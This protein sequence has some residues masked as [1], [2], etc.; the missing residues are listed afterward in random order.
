MNFWFQESETNMNAF[1]YKIFKLFLI[2]KPEA[3]VWWTEERDTKV[4]LRTRT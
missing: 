3:R 2:M 1:L 4:N